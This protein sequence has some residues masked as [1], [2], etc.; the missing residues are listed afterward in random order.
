[1]TFWFCVFSSNKMP[2]AF[3]ILGLRNKF[4]FSLVRYELGFSRSISYCLGQEWLVLR[5][6][7]IVIVWDKKDESEKDSQILSLDI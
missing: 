1:M 3:K 6:E 2:K 4:F 7:E 5:K